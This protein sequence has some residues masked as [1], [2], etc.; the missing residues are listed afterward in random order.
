MSGSARSQNSSDIVH[1]LKAFMAYNVI[2]VT[3]KSNNLITDKH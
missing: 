3:S 1:D 2:Q